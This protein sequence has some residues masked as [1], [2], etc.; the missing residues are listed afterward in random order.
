MAS[1]RRCAMTI[2][3]SLLAALLVLFGLAWPLC[4]SAQA[5][6]R[7]GQGTEYSEKGADTCLGCHDPDSDSPGFTTAAIFKTKHAQ[8][9][10]PHAPFGKGGLQCEACHGPGARHAMRGSDKKGTINS[11]KANS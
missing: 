4:A 8:R 9:A 11:L 3:T 2:R 6:E 7:P 1:S 10:D 5:G